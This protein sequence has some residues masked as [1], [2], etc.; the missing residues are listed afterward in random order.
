MLH[1]ANFVANCNAIPKLTHVL[2]EVLAKTQLTQ[3]RFSLL[4]KFPL[5]KMRQDIT[6]A[7]DKENKSEPLTHI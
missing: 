7:L 4:A 3:I 6:W 5:D 2:Y 1:D